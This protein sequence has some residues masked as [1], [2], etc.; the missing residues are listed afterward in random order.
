MV[1]GFNHNFVYNGAV[2]HVQTEDHGPRSPS[3]VTL[4]YRDGTILVSRKVSYADIVRVDNLEQVVAE[5][6]KEQH[7]EV[8]RSLKSGAFNEVIARFE[9]R[10]ASAGTPTAA[11]AAANATDLERLVLA[12]LT[13]EE[14]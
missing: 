4:L 11:P 5:L 7:Q 2:Y 12:Y 13:G 14:P 8:L 10:P 3:I 9:A 1:V 6:M